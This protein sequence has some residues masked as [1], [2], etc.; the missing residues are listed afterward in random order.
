MEKVL[1]EENGKN[2]FD[3]Y[4]VPGIVTTSSGDVL[5]TYEGRGEGDRRVLFMRRSTDGGHSF[6][7]GKSLQNQ[8]AKNCCIILF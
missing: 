6:C 1:I 5:L 8:K 2:G 7:Q 3:W 4:R